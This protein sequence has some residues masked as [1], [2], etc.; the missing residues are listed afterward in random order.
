MSCID[1]DVDPTSSLLKETC[2]EPSS[3]FSEIAVL[4]EVRST[5][6]AVILLNTP[7]LKEMHQYS[8]ELAGSSI[9]RST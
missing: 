1:V 3:R 5:R 7:I 9:L 4:Y 6:T 8:V 2:D